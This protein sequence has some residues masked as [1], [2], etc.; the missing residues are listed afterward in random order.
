[1]NLLQPLLG[2]RMETSKIKFSITKV[3]Y[4]PIKGSLIFSEENIKYNLNLN[5]RFFSSSEETI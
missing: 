2:N 5:L 4:E 3:S 1:M